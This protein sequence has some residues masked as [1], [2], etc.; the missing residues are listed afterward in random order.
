MKSTYIIDT[1]VL[2][3][4]PHSFKK[5]PKGSEVVLPIYV[6]DELDKLK[7]RPD[8]A[9]KNSRVCIRLLDEVCQKGS[10][11]KGIR[12]DNNILFKIDS[13]VVPNTFG[14]PEYVDNKILS[15]AYIYQQKN[16]KK[17]VP[18]ATILVSRDINLRVRAEAIGVKSQSYESEQVE[19]DDQFL[20]LVNIVHE[21]MGR[22]LA[23]KGVIDCCTYDELHDLKQNEGVH[24]ENKEGAGLAMGRRVGDKLKLIKSRKPWGLDL[25]NKE[26]AFAV[27]LLADP[28]LPL[29]SLIGQAGTGKT[30][31][32]IAAALEL[33]IDKRQFDRMIIYRPVHT[34]GKD[35][36]YLPGTL[37]EKLYPH[38]QAIYDAFEF[39]LTSQKGDKWKSMFELYMDKGIIQLDTMAYCRGRS[40]PN[41]LMIIDEAQNL[42][43]EEMKTI[44]TR[45]SKGTKIIL[46]GDVEQIDNN[47][48]DS[49]NNGL[50]FVVEKFKNSTLSGHVTL[51]KG[52]R[53]ELSAEAARL[54]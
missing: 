41:T 21:E 14:P 26:Q 20:G 49:I 35:L 2:A 4:D 10:V 12:I 38:M 28:K 8:A 30:V 24:I 43:K 31:I 52:E 40:I 9:G 33:V 16:S 47:S 53:S 46:T 13:N 27:E 23:E 5:F 54:L 7:S 42:S 32:T 17:K 3:H 36:G 39:L 45:A 44:L 48:L 22:E 34:V 51:L 50:S 37:E 6:L 1:C 15:C 19:N 29:V 25:R 18:T 11:S